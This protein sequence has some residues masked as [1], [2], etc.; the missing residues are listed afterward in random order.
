MTGNSNCSS[1]KTVYEKAQKSNSV[2][3]EVK[4]TNRSTSQRDWNYKTSQTEILE[5]MKSI[6]EMKAEA[7]SPGNGAG[8]W[9]K[10]SVILEVE[11]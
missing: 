9:R 7:V 4:S 3:S 5:L 6:N 10:E 2:S 11:T 1:E 8:R